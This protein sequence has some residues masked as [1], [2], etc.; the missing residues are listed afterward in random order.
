[1]TYGVLGPS[2]YMALGR[3]AQAASKPPG[4]LDSLPRTVTPEPPQ[5]PE[6]VEARSSP[7]NSVNEM[8]R[9]LYD[10][11]SASRGDEL[12]NKPGNSL[13]DALA[14][15]DTIGASA[16]PGAIGILG[17]STGTIYD[18]LGRGYDTTNFN[19][20]GF[21]SDIVGAGLGGL[22]GKGVSTVGGLLGAELGPNYA[23][24]GTRNTA[25][26][27]GRGIKGMS[28]RERDSFEA[29][30]AH[31]M[32]RPAP[33]NVTSNEARMR[34]E[35]QRLMAGGYS[36]GVPGRGNDS[37]TPGS[38]TTG[39]LSQRDISRVQQAQSRAAATRG[40]TPW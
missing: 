13:A 36:G 14:G 18:E 1:M 16:R 27:F 31:V 22:L 33:T 19:P 37:N 29:A 38:Q 28:S 2:G 11:D 17:L 26:D 25:L 39:A 8:A 35:A 6:K 10:R 15:V 20:I 5:D 3:M 7:S 34:A 30:R 12:S 9:M 32:N 40:R 24:R 23:L 4:G 21:G